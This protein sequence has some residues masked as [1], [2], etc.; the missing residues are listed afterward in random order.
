MSFESLIESRIRDAM[1]EGAFDGL[2][3]EGEPLKTLGTEAFAGDNW[4]GFHILENGGMLPAWLLLGKEI[5]RDL[6]H[7]EKL[8]AR[9][10]ELLRVA[11]NSGDV[12]RFR[13]DLDI[14]R[15]AFRSFAIATRKKQD[16]FNF[17]APVAFPGGR[18][19]G[20]SSNWSGWRL[21][22]TCV[23]HAFRFRLAGTLDRFVGEASV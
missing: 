7:L 19:C 13:I 17:D 4:L 20:L 5:E 12:S 15:D 3:G 6:W 10:R 23:R 16:Q 14:R 9:Y 11:R 8:R 18:G 1:E 21:E 2:K 22:K